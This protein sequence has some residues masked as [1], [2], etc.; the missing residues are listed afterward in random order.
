MFFFQSFN[1]EPVKVPKKYH[2]YFWVYGGS[3]RTID[4]E[5]KWILRYAMSELD[6][7]M[8]KY[9]EMFTD[10]FRYFLNKYRND[11]NSFI[12]DIKNF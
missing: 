1:N 2:L 3:T 6:F 7:E 9:P 10:D 12:E 5:A 4:R 11:M 8:E